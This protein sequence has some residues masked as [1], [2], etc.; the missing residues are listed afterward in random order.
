MSSEERD[1]LSIKVEWLSKRLDILERRW[2]EL[3]RAQ[4]GRP[5]QY[6]P[7]QYRASRVSYDT[8][9]LPEKLF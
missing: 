6:R 9:P 8:S 1:S 5:I 4:T 3:A 2:T 7:S